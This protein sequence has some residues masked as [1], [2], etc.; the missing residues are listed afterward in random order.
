MLNSTRSRLVRRACAVGDWMRRT[1]VAFSRQGAI[2]AT[3]SAART[4]AASA[5][6]TTAAPAQPFLWLFA[7]TFFIGVGV[8]LYLRAD[9]GAPPYDVLLSGV[10]ARVGISHGQ[11]GWLVGSVFLAL[12][13]GLGRRPR[14]NTL[15]FILLN[16]LFIDAARPLIAQ[17]ETLVGRGFF[18]ALGTLSIA[19]GLSLIIHGGGTGG[20]F[21]MTVRAIADRGLPPRAVRTSIEFSVLALGVLLEGSI[22]PGTFVF[23]LLIAPTLRVVEQNLSDLRAG[24]DLRTSQRAPSSPRQK[25][26][27]RT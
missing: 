22:G 7:G 5:A 11:G 12:A 25:R 27:V 17:P 20:P 3:V 19:T 1:P 23:A 4:T 18:V 24:R 10:A 8:T 9:L 6:R 2:Q 21:D 13:F 26:T 15:F 16:G 14:V